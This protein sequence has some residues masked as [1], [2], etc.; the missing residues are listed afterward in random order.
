MM[1]SIAT[2]F[3]WRRL[4]EQNVSSEPDRS[5]AS[6]EP[7]RRLSLTLFFFSAATSTW[8]SFQKTAYKKTY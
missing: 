7:H 5:A 2:S 6:R 3:R 8:D 1:E 4:Q